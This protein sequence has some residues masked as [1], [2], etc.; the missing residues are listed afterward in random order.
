[1]I[2]KANWFYNEENL[3][4]PIEGN[5]AK[6]KPASIRGKYLRISILRVNRQF[7][8]FFYVLPFTVTR[9]H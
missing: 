5:V 6:Y 9:Q 8:M 4:P 3:S 1:M 7:A 2:P